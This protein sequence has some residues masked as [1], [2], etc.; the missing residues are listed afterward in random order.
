MRHST[1]T[2]G[3]ITYYVIIAISGLLFGLGCLL[4]WLIQV[5]I[6]C[7]SF[8]FILCFAVATLAI[9]FF[10]RKMKLSI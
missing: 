1:S 5:L 10:K 3:Y 6:E 8:P 2:V 4:L 9:L 7:L